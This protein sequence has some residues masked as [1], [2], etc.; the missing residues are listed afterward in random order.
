MKVFVVKND[1][2]ESRRFETEK[3]TISVGRGSH[4]DI[5]VSG[6]GASRDHGFF[7]VSGKGLKFCDRSKNGSYVNG[8]LFVNKDVRLRLGDTVEI[9]GTKIKFYSDVPVSTGR[10][11]ALPPGTAAP[12]PAGPVKVQPVN[13][14]V[15]AP[16]PHKSYL[17]MSFLIFFLYIF[18]WPLGLI[19][20]LVLFFEARKFE[21][22]YGTPPEGKGCLLALIIWQIAMVAIAVIT[23]ILIV[24]GILSLSILGL[25][26]S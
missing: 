18:L 22:V 2:G 6:D 25:A 1:R 10:P 9:S 19:L 7:E 23:V 20:N 4:N 16:P 5:V 21:R 8:A 13:V 12:Q 24:L 17:G 3:S 14:N 11:T 15:S 26:F